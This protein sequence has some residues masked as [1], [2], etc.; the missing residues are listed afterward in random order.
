[1]TDTINSPWVLADRYG[2]QNPY[3]SQLAACAICS[4]VDYRLHMVRQFGQ[5]RCPDCYDEPDAVGRN[6]GPSRGHPNRSR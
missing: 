5:W 2:H 4:K 6:R 1:M 3:V